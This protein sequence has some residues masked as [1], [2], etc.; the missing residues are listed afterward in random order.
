MQQQ[1]VKVGAAVVQQRVGLA[2]CSSVG[3]C[4]KC[5]H[6]TWLALRSVAACPDK[7]NRA[8][9]AEGWMPAPVKD[10]VEHAPVLLLCAAVLGC[11][12]FWGCAERR[13]CHCI[14]VSEIFIAL[15]KPENFICSLSLLSNHSVFLIVLM[16]CCHAEQTSQPTPNLFHKVQSS[17]QSSNKVRC[18]KQWVY[19]VVRW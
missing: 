19:V 1:Y 18:Y 6:D 13:V 7:S 8:V 17:M 9:L 11:C 4:V 15:Q 14:P 16:S 3:S 2:W 10:C 5:K 12:C